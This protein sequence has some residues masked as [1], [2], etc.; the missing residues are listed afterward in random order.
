MPLCFLRLFAR[1]VISAQ[2]S[3]W[4]CLPRHSKKCEK[5]GGK[6]QNA[7]CEFGGKRHFCTKK[8]G[9]ERG[10]VFSLRNHRNDICDNSV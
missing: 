5:F 4:A 8:F 2:N 3:D 7:H 1:D 6:R 10:K 9:G